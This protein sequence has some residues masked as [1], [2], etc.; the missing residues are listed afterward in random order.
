[1]KI[2]AVESI[3][4]SNDKAKEISNH[5]KQAGH[6]FILHSDRQEDENAL[7]DRMKDADIAIVSNIKLS[8]K[9]L[10]A[11]PR[12]KMLDIAF[13]GVDHVDLEYCRSHNITVCNASGYATEAVSELAI[14]LM[15]DVY[16]NITPL[17]G[18]TRQGGTRNNFLGRQLSGKT[19]GIIGTGAIGCRTA[20]LLQQFGCTIYAW[21]RSQKKELTNAGIKYVTLDELLEVSDIISLHVPLT[22]DTRHIINEEKLNKCKPGAILINTARGNVV[23]LNALVKALEN[24]TIAAAAFD[25]FDIEPPLPKSHILFSAPNLWLTPHIGY[26]TRESFDDRIDIVLQNIDAYLEGKVINNVL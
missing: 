9:V 1:M 3:G 10:S 26:A 20:L 16:R 6:E 15:L 18:K 22:A 2:V 21:N 11:C 23:D 17:D 25:V 5:Y 24:N 8:Q 7:I 12:L 19:V 4:I 14:G 13:T